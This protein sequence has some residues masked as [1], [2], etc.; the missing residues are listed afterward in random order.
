MFA[1]KCCITVF[2]IE[3][4]KMEIPNHLF[5]NEVIKSSL[6]LTQ[7]L[8]GF[9]FSKNFIVSKAD[10][11]VYYWTDPESKSTFFQLPTHIFWSSGTVSKKSEK[12]VGAIASLYGAIFMESLHLSVDTKTGQL[13]RLG[14]SS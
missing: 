3:N 11:S 5:F 2:K 6:L 9:Y 4:I 7:N 10:L 8:E 14:N 13:V 1:N 12:I